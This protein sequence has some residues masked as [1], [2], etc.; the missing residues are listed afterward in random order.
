MDHDHGPV[1]VSYRH[2]DGTEPARAVTAVLRACGL[3]VWLDE[4]AMLV[5][6][7][8]YRMD[9]ALRSGASAGVLVATPDVRLSK[10]IQTVE[11]PALARLSQESHMLLGVVSP[12]R[13][14]DG[15]VDEQATAGLYDPIP[16]FDLA[17]HKHY[18]ADRREDLF[19]LARDFVIDRMRALRPETE[20]A[21]LRIDVATRNQASD[22]DRTAAHLDVR[23]DIHG[24]GLLPSPT[25]MDL[26]AAAAPILTQAFVDSGAT[27]V[28]FSGNGHLSFLLALG[29][30]FPRSRCASM[31]FVDANGERWLSPRTALA[32]PS[33]PLVVRTA[34]PDATIVSAAERVLVSIEVLATGYAPAAVSLLA[35][36]P[37]GWR[38][39]YAITPSV[40][41]NL[42]SPADAEAWANDICAD[43]VSVMSEAGVDELHLLYSGPAALAPLI[44]RNLTGYAV[45]AYEVLD[46]FNPTKARYVPTIA[47]KVGGA[48]TQLRALLTEE[49]AS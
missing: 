3:S 9:E 17:D 6:S 27:S 15:S 29:A 32:S 4:Y 31:A 30:V 13:R 39:A 12:L 7:F 47:I 41:G 44:G 28:E 16:D 48:V 24:E 35:A 8:T 26:F 18:G 36:D 2:S 40:P 22:S 1:F 45:T 34:I 38:A 10:A 5:G 46:R 19:S 33:Q 21:V 11:F 23:L 37:A 49:S 25:G 43:L 14:S 20:R 42:L